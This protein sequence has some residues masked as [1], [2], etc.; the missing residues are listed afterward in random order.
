MSVLVPA[1]TPRAVVVRVHR[2]VT[3]VSRMPE[4]ETRFAADAADL[5]AEQP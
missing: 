4:I 5:N 2:D 1:G 3:L